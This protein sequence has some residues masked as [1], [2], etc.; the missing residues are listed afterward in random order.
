MRLF[1]VERWIRYDKAASARCR[2][3]TGCGGR[4]AAAAEPE[5]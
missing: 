4:R 5:L 1:P 3:M 2:L